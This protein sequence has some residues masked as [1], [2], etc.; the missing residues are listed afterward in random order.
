MNIINSVQFSNHTGACVDVSCF[1]YHS[2][3][4]G[5]KQCKGQVLNASDLQEIVLGLRG[6][7]L[8][9][10]YTHLLTGMVIC[11]ATTQILT[12]DL[13]GLLAGYVG[14]PS[15]LREV[16]HLAEE[17]KQLSPHLVF[18]EKRD[19]CLVYVFKLATCFAYPF[20]WYLLV[21]HC[22]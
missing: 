8:L 15:F 5:Y 20:Y 6:N 12:H 16:Q 10:N 13:D 3:I 19:A 17:L 9:C 22:W 21:C 7:N 1:T 14:S 11:T 18:G 2:T 4:V